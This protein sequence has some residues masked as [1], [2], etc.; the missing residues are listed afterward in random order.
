MPRWM[1]GADAG[2]CYWQPNVSL[3]SHFISSCRL[4]SSHFYSSVLYYSCSRT[5][6]ANSA[7]TTKLPRTVSHLTLLPRHPPP[8]L[9]PPQQSLRMAWIIPRRHRQPQSDLTPSPGLTNAPP[10]TR[11]RS[12]IWWRRETCR[13]TVRGSRTMTLWWKCIRAWGGSWV[14]GAGVERILRESEGIL[15]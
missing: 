2:K 5:C 3:C 7:T 9:Q 1:D 4:R 13:S 11:T 12:R 10:S 15:W 14:C 8:Q 6:L